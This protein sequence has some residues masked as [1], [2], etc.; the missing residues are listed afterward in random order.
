MELSELSVRKFSDLLG[1]DAPAPGGGSAAA[2]HGAMGAALDAMVCSLTIGRKKYADF[3]A[4][5]S[6][7]LPKA[8][9]LKNRFLAAMETDTAVFSAF[10]ATLSLPKD[11]EEEKAARTSAIQEA[12]IH[13]TESPLTI[14]ELALETLELTAL[15]LGK[16]NASAASDVGV[17]ALSLRACIQSAWLNVVI[18]LNSLRDQI[19]I[20]HFRQKGISLLEK[21]LPLADKVYESVLSSLSK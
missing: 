19:L 5:A 8:S 11:T 20:E 15:L 7:M 9:D 1:S 13:C 14:M 3:E 16:T 21:A 18:N 12:L 4:F 2:I 6:E 10:S 17:A